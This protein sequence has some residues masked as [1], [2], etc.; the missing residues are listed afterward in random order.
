MST[1]G[2]TSAFRLPTLEIVG[3][4]YYE[5]WPGGLQTQQQL[6][7]GYILFTPFYLPASIVVR[8]LLCWV[9]TVGDAGSK[10][11]LGL[12]A[13]NGFGAPR[14]LAAASPAIASDVLGPNV[15]VLSEPAT[16]VSGWVWTA[17][18]QVLAPTTAATCD[19]YA[20]ANNVMPFPFGFGYIPA[21]Q[22]SVN[23]STALPA[24]GGQ[25]GPLPGTV[26]AGMTVSA[27]TIRVLVGT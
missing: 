12:Y 19:G 4:R 10:I 16:V 22:T 24:I 26:P 9:S 14:Q 13:D 21:A 1:S 27:R 17:I 23:G 2:G 6:L 25:A 7:N 3:G 5:P 11:Y 15:G 20:I 18:L 8:S